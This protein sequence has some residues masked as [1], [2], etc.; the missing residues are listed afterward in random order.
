MKKRFNLIQVGFWVALVLA[1]CKS[2]TIGNDIVL[3]GTLMAGLLDGAKVTAYDAAGQSLGTT[4]SL[5]GEFQ[6]TLKADD[7]KSTLVIQSSGGSYEDEATGQQVTLGS[8]GLSAVIAGNSLVGA[9]P[10]VTLD[11]ATTLIERA[12]KDWSRYHSGVTSLEVAALAAEQAFLTHFGFQPQQ[13]QKPVEVTQVMTGK[14]TL[15]AKLAGF[16]AA[17]FS[18][19]AFKLTKDET[20]QI[21]MLRALGQDLAD[22]TLNGLAGSATVMLGAKK[23]PKD[24]A[25]QFA[26]SMLEFL[27][28]TRNQSGLTTD[29]LGSLPFTKVLYSTSYKVEYIPG[30]Q[31]AMQGKTQFSLKVTDLNGSP[32]ASLP[33]LSLTPKMRMPSMTHGTPQAGCA[34]S[35]SEATVFTCALYYLMASSVNNMSMGIW[36]LGVKITQNSASE[37]VTF[38]PSVKMGTGDGVRVD[39]KGV[40][41]QRMA[42]A[43]GM[44]ARP[45]YLFKESLDTAAQSATFFIAVGESM[46]SVPALVSGL[47]LNSGTGYALTVNQVV[48]EASMDQTTWTVMSDLGKGKYKATGLG[49]TSGK[50]NS[51]FVR[52]SVNGEQKTTDGQA[53]AGSNGYQTF[54]FTL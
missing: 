21:A 32:L 28:S 12:A 38:F 41:D 44:E 36:S 2:N 30:A 34:Q 1:G 33:S 4:Q 43:G 50:A 54:T 37:S 45:Y 10:L 9:A 53:A 39:L 7:L 13:A 42:M 3:D 48:A 6:L 17:A 31:E 49:L 23:L 47:V 15:E 52:L 29:K 19:M 40:K 26:L 46:M 27:D 51:V 24:G 5:K 8:E 18:Q 35:A 22:G 14:E 20:Q 16:R 25:N 11:P